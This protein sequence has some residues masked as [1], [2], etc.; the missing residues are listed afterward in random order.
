VVEAL[1]SLSDSSRSPLASPEKAA[2]RPHTGQSRFHKWDRGHGWGYWA[3]VGAT[4]HQSG[5]LDTSWGYWDTT[6][7]NGRDSDE[8]GRDLALSLAYGQLVGL[9]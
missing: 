1:L 8:T 5:L 6:G 9:A 2:S 3:S 4:G 7:A